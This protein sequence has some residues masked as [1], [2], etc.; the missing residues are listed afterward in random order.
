M[1]KTKN[2]YHEQICEG[3]CQFE[4]D[5]YQFEE[6]QIQQEKAA[7]E[8]EAEKAAFFRTIEI[9]GLRPF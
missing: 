3:L 7:L 4:D 1:S 5:S 2:F 9:F 6:Y 8:Y